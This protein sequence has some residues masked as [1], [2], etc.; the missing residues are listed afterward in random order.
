MKGQ[1][2]GELKWIVS[3]SVM[4]WFEF[5]KMVKHNEDCYCTGPL[6]VPWFSVSGVRGLT[7][8]PLS[9]QC[10]A[11]YRTRARGMEESALVHTSPVTSLQCVKCGV[12]SVKCTDV[13]NV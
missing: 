1:W 10:A 11:G 3:K 12:E 13:C 6:W 2:K 7:A 8:A 5:G 4:K 9:A